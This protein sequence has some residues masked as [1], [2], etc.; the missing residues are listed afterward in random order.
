MRAFDDNQNEGNVTHPL[1]K[2]TQTTKKPHSGVCEKDIPVRNTTVGLD[3]HVKTTCLLPMRVFY[4]N[5]KDGEIAHAL[6]KKTQKMKKPHSG[7]L[8]K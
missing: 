1:G 5:R 3:F 2:K 6:R 4:V 8:K 7:V